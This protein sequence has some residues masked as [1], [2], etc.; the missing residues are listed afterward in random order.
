M[1]L[2]EGLLAAALAGERR[3]V[4]R[5]ITLLENAPSGLAGA[6]EQPSAAAT[7]AEIMAAIYPHTG[8]AQ[9]VGMTGP[10]GGGKSTL[11]ARLAAEYRRRGLMVGIVAVDPSSPFSGGA[12]LGDRIRMGA[13]S[14][15]SGVFIRSMAN[16]GELGGL[17]RSTAGVVAVLDACGFRRILVETVGTGQAEVEIARTAHA[18]VVVQVPEMGDEIQTMKAGILEIAD[19]LVVNKADHAGAARTV[20]ALGAMLDLRRSVAAEA[21]RPPIVQTVATRGEGC[22]EL[23]DALDRHAAYLGTSGRRAAQDEARARSTLRG[24]LHEALEEWLLTLLGR[25]AF[26]EAVRQVAQRQDDPYGMA[27]ALLRRALQEAGGKR[28]QR[29]EDTA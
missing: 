26:E 23:V 17:A 18:T 13:L 14:G 20:A 4:A 11:V 12:I 1:P 16:R 3:A 15:D 28:P 2:P 6:E 21:W 29:G 5:L 19:V 10:P 7:A 8:Q 22:A 24:V 27:T 25:A 9:V